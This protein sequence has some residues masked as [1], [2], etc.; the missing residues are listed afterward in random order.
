MSPK[1]K[2]KPRAPSSSFAKGIST[3]DSEEIAKFNRHGDTWWQKKGP[4]KI[5]H[6]F[7]AARLAYICNQV[8][9]HY[10]L[11]P[12]YEPL[13]GLR[14]LDIGCGGGILCE[15]LA[16]LGATVTGI[17]S[18]KASIQAARAHAREQN[19]TITYCVK[20]VEDMP[21]TQRYDIILAMEIMEHVKNPSA[22]LKLSAA[23]LKPRGLFITGTLNRTVASFLLAIVG[24]EYVLKWLPKRTHDWRRF[25]TPQEMS[26]MMEKARLSPLHHQGV[27]YDPL[28]Q[29]WQ[30]CD[31]TR[32]NYMT[33]AT[34]N[35]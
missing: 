5:L 15:P 18:A 6:D 24:A 28:R 1:S 2:N 35:S 23:L 4:F 12:S 29:S 22:F 30:A 33:V 20:A 8:H 7:N 32:V 17:D 27:K 14:I 34:K 16:R 26:G 11:T 21:P 25:L 10:N 13:R 31:T 3:Q 9:H 19:L